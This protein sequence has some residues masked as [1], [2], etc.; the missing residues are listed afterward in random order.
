MPQSLA[1]AF[2]ALVRRAPAAAVAWTP[3]GVVSRAQLAAQ[4]QVLADRLRPFAGQRVA[5]SVRDPGQLL[6]AVLATWQQAGCALLL[7][8]ADPQAPRTDLAAQF[9]AAAMRTASLGP[10]PSRASPSVVRCRRC[11]SPP[12]S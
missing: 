9:G 2:A 3:V 6:V 11:R 1:D 5:I 4:A 12:S 7:D 8:A 10:P